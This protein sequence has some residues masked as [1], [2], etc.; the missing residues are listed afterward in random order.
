MKEAYPKEHARLW[1]SP[2][3]PELELMRATYITHQFPKHAHEGFAIGVVES[4]ELGFDYRGSHIVAGQGMVNLANAG[5]AHNGKAMTDRGWTYRMFYFGNDLLKEAV[6]QISDNKMNTLP[7]FPEGVL[8]HP[9][10]AGLLWQLHIALELETLQTLQA[11]TQ[12]WE[13]LSLL[14]KKHADQQI[15]ESALASASLQ[16]QRTCDLIRDQFQDDLTLSIL[17]DKAHLSPFH[18]L[19]LFQK[20]TGMPPHQ[21]LIQ[22]RIQ[23]A[24]ALIRQNQSLVQ[25]ALETGFADQSHFNRHFK[26]IVGISPGKYRKIVQE[27]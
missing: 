17:A 9:R 10:L 23:K 27:F 11:E 13:I 22:Y 16:I 8:S 2:H 15:Q 5:E 26:R 4:G 1:R 25:T 12:F 14:I 6:S 18:F 19:R 7:Y 21:Y 20:E 3:L 24:K